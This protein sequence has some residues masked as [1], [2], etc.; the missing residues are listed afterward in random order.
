MHA[1]ASLSPLSSAS[2]VCD[3]LAQAFADDPF[4][5]AVTVAFE[6]DAVRRRQVLARYFELAIE[7]A[8]AVGEVR[9]TGADGAAVWVT[10]EAGAADVAR[11]GAARNR[12]LEAL[13][14]PDGYG[15]Y[16]RICEAMAARVPAHLANA[17]Y[18]SILGVRAEARGRGLAQVMLE[19]TLARADRLGA[20]CFLETFNP[21]SIPFYERLGFAH[22][23]ECF[24][25]V[26]GRPYWILSRRA[27]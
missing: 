1:P 21:L 8:R 6:V 27:V 11:H 22:E 16:A 13:L 15:N 12:A 14:G 5:R 18:L 2:A 9:S 3:S 26:T 19:P 17:W 24:E 10:N 7:E 25:A 4:Y 23:A 20:A